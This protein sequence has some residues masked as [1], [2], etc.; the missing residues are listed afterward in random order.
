[1][2]QVRTEKARE[3]RRGL[4]QRQRQDRRSPGITILLRLVLR[5]G[6]GRN[7]NRLDESDSSLLLIVATRTGHVSVYTADT[8]LLHSALTST[9]YTRI[10]RTTRLM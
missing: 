7:I 3:E 9:D 2:D 6:Y 8:Y 4:G 10:K 5:L 1:M